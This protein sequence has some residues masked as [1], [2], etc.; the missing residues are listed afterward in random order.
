[1][2]VKYKYFKILLLLLINLIIASNNHPIFLLHGFMGWGR[3][4]LSNH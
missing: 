2:N 4:E 3:D 1:M